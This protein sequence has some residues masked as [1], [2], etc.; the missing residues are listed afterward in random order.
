MHNLFGSVNEFDSHN[1]SR[2]YDLALEKLCVTQCGWIRLYTEVA[3]GITI[4]IFWKLFFVGLIE[5]TMK[6]KL[7]SNNYQNDLLLIVLKILFQLI[8]GPQKRTYLPLMRYMKDKQFLLDMH[9]IFPV[10][11][12]LSYRSAL[13]PT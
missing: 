5:I 13:F 12:L 1:K 7:V 8:L 4:T 10:L 3:I 6:N 9:F 11:I 2:K